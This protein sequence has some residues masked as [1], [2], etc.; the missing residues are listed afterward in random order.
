MDKGVFYNNL[1]EMDISANLMNFV[2]EHFS[3]SETKNFDLSKS[4][5]HTFI[6]KM[7]QLEIL[8]FSD[9]KLNKNDM[10]VMNL[11]WQPEKSTETFW[12]NV[13]IL[14]LKSNN[15]GKDGIKMLANFLEKNSILE[16]LDLSNNDL[17]T[18]GA[19]TL[20]KSLEGN[21]SIKFLSIFDN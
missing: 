11:T 5:P 3:L 18:A 19:R 8:N 6:K 4:F 21:T 13:K 15:I 7:P 9:G 2:P 17:G 16:S 10:F 20:A 1:V 14:N 12:K